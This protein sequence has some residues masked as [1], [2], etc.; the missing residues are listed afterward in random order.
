MTLYPIIQPVA[1]KK[2][3]FKV[4]DQSC[5]DKEILII[6]K[7]GYFHSYCYFI[8]YAVRHKFSSLFLF[9]FFC[10]DKH[11]IGIGRKVLDY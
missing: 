8:D 4:L 9:L 5:C 11:F 10:W 3:A 2:Y 6:A 1:Y 7:V